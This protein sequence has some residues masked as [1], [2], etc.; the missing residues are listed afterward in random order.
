LMGT[1]R[2][3]LIRC[4]SRVL[5]VRFL[6]ALMFGFSIFSFDCA[7]PCIALDPAV[8]YSVCTRTRTDF[9][10]TPCNSSLSCPCFGLGYSALIL[11][12][13]FSLKLTFDNTLSI[14]MLKSTGT[15]LRHHP[16]FSKYPPYA[17]LNRSLPS[18]APNQ[19]E[20]QTHSSPPPSRSAVTSHVLCSMWGRCLRLSAHLLFCCL[21]SSFPIPITY[22]LSFL[23]LSHC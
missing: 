5:F 12:I 8:L 17:A 14:S 4:V 19:H 13:L 15:R 1:W 9:A 11:C 21:L 10:V 18:A 22:R 3:Q 6:L 2:G 7:P 23:S 16:R 20:H